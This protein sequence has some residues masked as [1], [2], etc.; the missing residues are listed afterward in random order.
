MG[1]A[2]WITKALA[3]YRDGKIRTIDLAPGYCCY[4]LDCWLITVAPAVRET[5]VTK[6]CSLIAMRFFNSQI[7]AISINLRSAL[8]FPIANH[9]RAIS[10]CFR[11]VERCGYQ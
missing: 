1:V 2:R 7:S 5:F 9:S 10:Y 4:G 3:H 8:T 6:I 11:H